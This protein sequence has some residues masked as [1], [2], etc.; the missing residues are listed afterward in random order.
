MSR[1]VLVDFDHCR[2][3]LG[4][5]HPLRSLFG[6]VFD[7]SRDEGSAIDG[8]PTSSGLGLRRP[9]G[10]QGQFDADLTELSMWALDCDRLPHGLWQGSA[11]TRLKGLQLLLLAEWQG[12]EDLFSFPAPD[13]LRGPFHPI[14]KGRS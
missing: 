4:F 8:W 6:Q 5:D 9:I 14:P 2:I 7:P 11:W 1:H 3:V 10:D 12:G 13:N